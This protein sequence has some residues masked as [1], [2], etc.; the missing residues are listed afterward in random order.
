MLWKLFSAARPRKNLRNNDL[1][2][3]PGHD[4]LACRKNKE[5]QQ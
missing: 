5:S 2:T 1:R 4:S 3:T